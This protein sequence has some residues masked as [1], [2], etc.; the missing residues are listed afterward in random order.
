MWRTA[1]LSSSTVS[2][3]VVQAVKF[4]AIGR[5][6][7]T[8]LFN[9]SAGRTAESAGGLLSFSFTKLV[10]HHLP[11]GFLKKTQLQRKYFKG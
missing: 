3:V 4:N 7:K 10:S 8:L 2:C 5:T 1:W 9:M 11:V 6:G